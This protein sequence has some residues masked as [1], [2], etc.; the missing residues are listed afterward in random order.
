MLTRLV[1]TIQKLCLAHGWHKAVSNT[2]NV[3]QSR[4]NKSCRQLGVCVVVGLGLRMMLLHS[5][6]SVTGA[7][8]A[9]NGC[10][11][12]GTSKHGLRTPQPSE[13]QRK[14]LTSRISTPLAFHSLPGQGTL[15]LLGFLQS[16][17]LL[18]AGN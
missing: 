13:H 7:C 12:K 2:A 10:R 14:N 4:S 3:Y 15:G 9:A 11:Y 8:P 18:L 5:F 6:G 1:G 17:Q 16:T